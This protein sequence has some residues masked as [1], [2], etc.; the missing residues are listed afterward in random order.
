MKVPALDLDRLR[1]SKALPHLILA[2]LNLRRRS[3]GLKDMAARWSA[4][5]P[6][7]ARLVALGLTFLLLYGLAPA[8]G[9]PDMAGASDFVEAGTASLDSAPAPRAPKQEIASSQVPLLPSRPEGTRPARLFALRAIE[10]SALSGSYE[11]RSKADGTREDVLSWDG[12]AKAAPEFLL[13]VDSRLPDRA[14]PG[15]NLYLRT[16]RRAADYGLSVA[17]HQLSDDIV[18][19]FGKVETAETTFLSAAH[20]RTQLTC[21]SFF[22]DGVTFRMSGWSCGSTDRTAL[23][24]ILDQFAL[25]DEARA[26]SGLRQVFLDAGQKRSLCARPLM[27][28]KPLIGMR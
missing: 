25:S 4:A 8:P 27:L 26:D 9:L 13:S 24:C 11:A 18:T 10:L 12:K 21:L 17:K 7:H 20:P 16:V 23:A 14:A 3:C 5:Q 28:R 22:R 19:R 15:A 1:R 6:M 2:A